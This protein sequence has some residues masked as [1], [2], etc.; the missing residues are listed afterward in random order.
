MLF[1]FLLGVCAP[2]RQ[3]WFLVFFFFLLLVES[4]S[5]KRKFC[6]YGTHSHTH[7]PKSY[8]PKIRMSA[9]FHCKWFVVCMMMIELISINYSNG[10]LIGKPRELRIPMYI[11]ILD[12]VIACLAEYSVFFF[13]KNSMENT[14]N[15]NHFDNFRNKLISFSPPHSIAFAMCDL[16]GSIRFIWTFYVLYASNFEVMSVRAMKQKLC[17]SW[18]HKLPASHAHIL[19]PNGIVEFVVREMKQ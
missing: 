18:A 1:Y 11:P 5:I 9:K 10:K 6:D 15:G 19:S 13:R 14:N 17:N 7:T 4:I 3:F 16:A 8:R 2:S 12:F